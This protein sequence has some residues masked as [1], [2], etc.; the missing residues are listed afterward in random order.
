MLNL[1]LE[2]GI[3]GDVIRSIMDAKLIVSVP[4]HDGLPVDR[5]NDNNEDDLDGL[6]A[7]FA[8]QMKEATLAALD[9]ITKEMERLSES[10]QKVNKRQAYFESVLKL[11]PW[12]TEEQ[13]IDLSPGEDSPLNEDGDAAVQYRSVQ[14]K[15]A[16]VL[17]EVKGTLGIHSVGSSNHNMASDFGGPSRSN[18][19]TDGRCVTENSGGSRVLRHLDSSNDVMMIGGS[20]VFRHLDSPID[21]MDLVEGG[22][23]QGSCFCKGSP[24]SKLNL[25]RG[26][27]SILKLSESRNGATRLFT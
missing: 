27:P 8:M 9:R 24:A 22:V 12:P 19:N 1:T 3:P 16:C 11:G 5:V 21:A 18:K 4:R 7:D 2:A 14:A 13:R 10:V 17:K 26:H 15:E 23:G 25:R 20:G 6:A